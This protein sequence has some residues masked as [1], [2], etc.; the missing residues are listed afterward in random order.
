MTKA[1]TKTPSKSPLLI[2][3]FTVFLDLVGFG[4][5]IPIQPFFAKSLGATP[6]VIT[7]LAASYSLMQFIFS[8]FWGRLS[9]R[10]G[11]RP[12]MLMSISASAVGYLIFGLAGTLPVLFAARILSGIGSANLGAAQAIIADSTAP[13]ERAK[14]MG[15]IGAAFGLGFIF[16]PALGGFLSQWGPNV[17]AFGASL[18][19]L[20]NLIFAYFKLPETLK[21]GQAVSSGHRVFSI[22]ALAKGLRHPEVG[23]LLIVTFF[24]TFGFAVME[25]VIGLFIEYHWVLPQALTLDLSSKMASK[26]TAYFL[27]V[28][29][30]TATFIQGYLVGRLNKKFTEQKLYRIGI[31]CLALSMVLVPVLGG[32]VPFKVFILLSALMAAGM[33]LMNPNITAFISNAVSKDEQ[34]GMLGLNQ[35]MSSLGRVFG[36]SISGLLF[37]F[38]P[39]APFHGAGILFLLALGLT[40]TQKT[41]K[42]VVAS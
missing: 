37:E 23:S 27:V 16:G 18:L 26:M 15:L 28:T 13:H 21:K 3:W 32:L 9:D 5:I 36:P 4:L 34:G 7:L 31:F 12:I 19:S 29:G 39:N 10:I 25:Q 11:R 8:P 6:T 14:G 30:L 38:S 24:A 35:S 42:L 40:L 1:Q 17:P 41:Q 20:A 33:G 22:K 2:A